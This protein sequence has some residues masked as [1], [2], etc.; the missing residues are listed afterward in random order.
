[1]PTACP[2][3][4]VVLTSLMAPSRRR[5]NPR[6]ARTPLKSLSDLLRL[7]RFCSRWPK[8]KAGLVIFG[9]QMS[10][11]GRTGVDYRFWRISLK[12]PQRVEAGTDNSIPFLGGSFRGIKIRNRAREGATFYPSVLTRFV[13]DFF[14][15]I[16][17]FET[18]SR[19]VYTSPVDAKPGVRG[20]LV[21]IVEE[22][23]P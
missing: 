13:A 2:I 18:S 11:S 16:G 12:S 4:R 10:R 22:Q 5:C 23:A 21:A 6:G 3:R 9:R 1:M 7:R 20:C 8:V 17:A 19:A 14:N 15:T